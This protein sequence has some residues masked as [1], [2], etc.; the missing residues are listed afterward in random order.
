MDQPDMAREEVVDPRVELTGAATVEPPTAAV[1]SSDL[2]FIQE[3][4]NQL[5]QTV[6]ELRARISTLENGATA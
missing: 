2:L 1:R 3:E 5:V 4:L 6:H